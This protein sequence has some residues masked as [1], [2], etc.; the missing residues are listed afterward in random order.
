[1]A[2][3][4]ETTL[5]AQLIADVND[6]I[7]KF[8]NDVPQAAQAGMQRVQRAVD[9]GMRQVTTGANKVAEE[10]R[11]SGENSGFAF[12]E[13]FR[14]IAAGAATAFLLELH[15]QFQAAADFANRLTNQMAI[16]GDTAD[17]IQRMSYALQG[18]GLNAE[19]AEYSMQNMQRRVA[20]AAEAHNGQSLF[21]RA[22]MDVQ[23]M[24]GN[25][26]EKNFDLIADK[27]SRLK[28]KT[29]QAQ[30]AIAA[31]GLQ[32]KQML[33]ALVQG[34]QAIEE[35]G[36][37][38]D[39]AGAKLD[40][41]SR[42]KLTA[43]ST[44]ISHVHSTMQVFWAEILA[45]MADAFIRAADATQR[46]MK[47]FEDLSHEQK[48]TAVF[49]AI[50]AAAV[51][52][53]GGLE[54]FRP[55]LQTF[56][57][58]EF[59]DGILAISRVMIPVAAAAGLFAVAFETNFANIRS[60]VAQLVGPFQV[61]MQ[62]MRELMDD[63]SAD[64]KNTLV[65]AWKNFQDALQPLMQ[66]ITDFIAD[67]LKN[68]DAIN[69]NRQIIDAFI[70]VAKALLDALSSLATTIDDLWNRLGALKTVIG[71]LI[72]GAI[73]TFILQLRGT[74]EAI[75]LV[76]KILQ[77]VIP[78]F[79]YLSQIPGQINL[80][81]VKMVASMLRGIADID[82]AIADLIRKIPGLG[83][84]ADAIRGIASAAIDSANNIE[85]A[86]DKAQHLIDVMNGAKE[87]ANTDDGQ[88]IRHP[89]QPQPAAKTEGGK[90]K[91]TGTDTIA[92]VSHDHTGNAIKQLRDQL[93]PYQEAIEDTKARI[94]DVEDAI[95]RLGKI[96]TADKLAALQ[97]NY[98]REIAEEVTL[99]K[100]SL[101][102]KNKAAS[103][104]NTM[105]S[106]A[107]HTTGKTHGAYIEATRAMH[108]ER[109]NA[110]TEYQAAI[111]KTITL[112][113]EE[114]AK[115][116]E[117]YKSIAD[118]KS[119]PWVDRLKA[120]N[121]YL[122][123]VRE[124][125]LKHLATQNEI[126]AAIDAQVELMKEQKDAHLSVEDSKTKLG[127]AKIDAGITARDSK[128]LGPDASGEAQHERDL[129]D[130][131]DRRT[132]AENNAASAEAT[133]EAAKA[134]LD[135]AGKISEE[136]RQ[137]L[138][139]DLN[140][141]E[142]ALIEALSNRAKAEQDVTNIE[143]QNSKATDA[144][145]SA[146]DG[147]VQKLN[148]PLAEALNL[149]KQH[150]DPLTSI[151]LVLVEHSKSFGD[152][153]N[154]LAAIVDRVAMILDALRPV[155]DFL[156]GV[157][158]G[159]TNVFL[160]LFNL[161]AS[162]LNVFGA[163]IDQIKLLNS[164]LDQINQKVPLLQIN[165]I[166]PTMDEYN[167][168]KNASLSLANNGNFADPLQAVIND[169]FRNN[170]SKLGSILGELIGIYL[171]IRL[172]HALTG[173]LQMRHITVSMLIH[174]AVVAGNSLLAKIGATL[175]I[176]TPMHAATTTNT[177][178]T[179]V[180][181]TVQAASTPLQ[182]GAQIATATNT[183][184]VAMALAALVPWIIGLMAVA[185]IFGVFGGKKS[186]PPGP[187]GSNTNPGTGYQNP[188]D[189]NPHTL[190]IQ[191]ALANAVN[192]NLAKLLGNGSTVTSAN[193]GYSV[194]PG[195]DMNSRERIPQEAA[196]P[197]MTVNIENVNGVDPAHVKA[198]FQPL[199]DDFA[200]MQT[201]ISRTQQATYGRGYK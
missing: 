149:I 188:V 187:D 181:T 158:I 128:V 154:V 119:V 52:A 39:S 176:H 140:A 152:I 185:S 70:G 171:V 155:V 87:A 164:N 36:S 27:I 66:D 77:W 14:L 127:N 59:V 28:D 173:V 100:Q 88:R 19:S 161:I 148:G 3:D 80:N 76:A 104:E 165:H 134:L 20:Q 170:L 192:M 139:A 60:Y 92:P 160:M 93:I 168:G 144:V 37:K 96:D 112:R 197:T 44:S 49:G 146:F 132:I 56:V 43:L 166:L 95:T 172:L 116:E 113:R 194:T 99:S 177:G 10:A 72:E 103:L 83:G 50:S 21:E 106:R 41:F 115:A 25:S 4:A 75:E 118:N 64:V 138:T 32:G 86:A 12:G 35:L 84:V 94:K 82:T 1:M 13:G 29:Q 142:Q 135:N 156:L 183:G 108:R 129:A 8:T 162:L 178:T 9:D 23:A 109:I 61:Y 145:R 42:E 163:H 107:A 63:V 22:G 105:N 190:T 151:F 179:A 30:L 201:T 73:M 122:A 57:K 74:A 136:E 71:W 131:V 117:Y 69:T 81:F 47:Q 175:G 15:Q 133:R 150:V 101:E 195:S 102:L 67:M 184:A 110:E 62:N 186:A 6:F 51:L 53:L 58:R 24:M 89:G 11:I 143:L 167:S 147:L 124:S 125:A 193:G 189:N 159:I 33:P 55:L 38:A 46:L 111:T 191:D 174:N 121:E 7:Q 68:G 200:R 2:A 17:N 34:G 126:T 79:L 31:F 85:T 16:S 130:A 114:V 97:R 26:A 141:K 40:N 180:G 65:P 90:K 91:T 78:A 182:D 199:F 18:F 98:N 48:L 196:A 198:A 120:A 45:P 5:V 123:Q 169:G 137:K 153:M 157:L 54:S